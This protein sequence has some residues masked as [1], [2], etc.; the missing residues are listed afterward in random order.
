MAHVEIDGKRC[1][2]CGACYTV[3][4][5]EALVAPEGNGAP[6]ME[7]PALCSACG[8]CVAVCPSG[9]LHHAALEHL[10]FAENTGAAVDPDAFDR[11][12]AAKRSVRR[13]RDHPLGGDRLDRILQ[14]GANAPQ[15]KNSRTLAFT[16]ITDPATIAAMEA[17]VADA[18]RKLLRILSPP[19]RLLLRC[20]KPSLGSE[21][22]KNLP[23]L[24]RLVRRAAAGENPVFHAAPCVVVV[25]APRANLLGRDDAVI[26]LQ[27]MMLR[28]HAD[29]IGS[30]IIGYA[31]ARPKPLR[32]ILDISRDRA[33]HAV[34]VF[35]YPAIPFRR[36]IR[37]EMPETTRFENSEFRGHT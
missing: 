30:C 15:A 21:L 31:A 3:C 1:T 35:G 2:A 28:A 19:V 29:G 18:Y 24:R 17:A 14:A 16:V 34:G 4:T 10:Q 33:I 25:H 12:L 5:K 7:D 20:L 11:F 6:A 27:Y 26:A 9:A 36:Q 22:K 37:R 8:H 32:G 23:G 13:Y